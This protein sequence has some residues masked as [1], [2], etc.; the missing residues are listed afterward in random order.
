MTDRAALHR[1]EFDP[2]SAAHYEYAAAADSPEADALAASVH[3]NPITWPDGLAPHPQ[4][5]TV[6]AGAP[7]PKADVLVV[8]YTVAEGYALADVLTPG[9]DTNAWHPY[10]HNWADLRKL[11]G[12]DGPSLRSGYAALWYPVEIAGKNVIVMK[13]ALHPAIDGPKL[14]IVTA[15]QQWITEAAPDLIITTG[16]AGGIGATTA[17]GDV[18]ITN[19]IIWDCQGQFKNEPFAH[20]T[21]TS[22]TSIGGNFTTAETLIQEATGGKYPQLPA[23]ITRPAQIT[24]ITVGPGLITCDSFLFSDTED[25]YG[26][27]A[28]APT[29]RTE[30]MDDAAL[31]LALDQ[32]GTATTQ[33]WLSIRDASDPEVPQMATIKDEKA[34]AGKIYEQYGYYTAANSVLACWATIT[35]TT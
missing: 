34:W 27:R 20:T 5:T 18:F 31:P 30:D 24:T 6:E 3:I 7:L 16:T 14:P 19:Q 32:A 13:S 4:D 8:T 28:Y 17:L 22:P 1:V 23:T 2:R 25:H 35:Q 21:Y 29:A 26:L 11:V 33:A 10:T 15:W 12:P 9:I